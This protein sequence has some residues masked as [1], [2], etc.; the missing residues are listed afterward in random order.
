MTD[1]CVDCQWENKA[2]QTDGYFGCPG[3]F[4]EF[5]DDGLII[6]CFFYKKKE[7]EKQ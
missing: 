1:L 7:A 2:I 4:Q 5:D 3:G 6:S